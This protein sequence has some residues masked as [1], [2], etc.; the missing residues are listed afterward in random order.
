MN[1]E[2]CEQRF[3]CLTTDTKHRPKIISGV[4]KNIRGSCRT[5]TYMVL[6]NNKG[7]FGIC[8]K[9]NLLTMEQCQCVSYNPNEHRKRHLKFLYN[10]INKE[11]SKRKWGN[12]LLPKYCIK[13]DGV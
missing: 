2:N 11:S 1:C 8:S 4:N 10:D 9:Y 12:K 3:I 13:K 6:N 5:C 7:K